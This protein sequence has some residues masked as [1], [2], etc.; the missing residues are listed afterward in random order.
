MRKTF[1]PSSPC[2]CNSKVECCRFSNISV[3]SC[4][5][6]TPGQTWTCGCNLSSLL[7]GADSQ[8]A[9]CPAGQTLHT[10]SL[11]QTMWCSVFQYSA[12][13]ERQPVPELLPPF[14]DCCGPCSFLFFHPL[15]RARTSWVP[16]LSDLCLSL[17]QTIS[18]I[19]R[20]R[21]LAFSK[22]RLS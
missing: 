4:M 13:P 18:R 3:Q 11:G 2:A 8:S 16:R 21:F 12:E 5:L 15:E 19:S 14:D 6:C 7:R 10:H 1:A 17:I 20:F 22:G 9:G